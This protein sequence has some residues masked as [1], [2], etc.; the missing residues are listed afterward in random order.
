MAH[1]GQNS[2]ILVQPLSVPVPLNKCMGRDQHRKGY[3][4]C[5]A[6]RTP[7]LRRCVDLWHHFQILLPIDVGRDRTK[8][9][10]VCPIANVFDELLDNEYSKFSERL[11]CTCQYSY[12]L[13]SCRNKFPIECL[14]DCLFIVAPLTFDSWRSILVEIFNLQIN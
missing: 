14:S 8:V 7:I 3:I 6:D 12:V 5:S 9:G 11:A 13:R 10:R 2:P 4:R 1:S